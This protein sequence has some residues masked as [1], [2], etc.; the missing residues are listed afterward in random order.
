MSTLAARRKRVVSAARALAEITSTDPVLI[1]RAILNAVVESAG[2]DACVF[3]SFVDVRGV[4]SFERLEAEG[5]KREIAIRAGQ[6]ATTHLN[7]VSRPPEPLLTGFSSPLILM[8]RAQFEASPH[9]REVWEPHGITEGAALHFYHGEEFLGSLIALW[10]RPKEFTLEERALL[11]PLVAPIRAGIVA[12]HCLARRGLPDETAHLLLRAGGE[13]EYASRGADVWLKRPGIQRALSRRVRELDRRR[14]PRLSAP[15]EA[16]EAQVVRLRTSEGIRYLVCLKPS[17]LIRRA[18]DTL[19]T[20]AQ[21]R[22]AQLAAVGATVSE[23]AQELNRSAETVRSHLAQVYRRLR[24]SNRVEL[25]RALEA[26]ST[27]N[28]T[29]FVDKSAFDKS[30][31]HIPRGT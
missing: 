20:P 29:E 22:V 21:L 15:L 23:I 2:S 27:R 16:A 25:A 1:R 6:A 9:Y 12:A 17:Q 31:L 10:M 26:P 19:L 18:A 28:A 3:Y 14:E 24:T 7:D 30:I 8:T 5:P 11:M 13:V 4:A